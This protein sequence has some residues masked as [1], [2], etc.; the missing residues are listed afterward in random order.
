MSVQLENSSMVI[1][2]VHP[3]S[4]CEGQQAC[5]IHALTSHHMRSWRQIFREDNGLM[6]RICEHGIGHPDPD[7]MHYWRNRGE[8]YMGIHGCDGCCRLPTR[9][10]EV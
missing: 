6:E 4:A 5:A 7:G 3:E 9:L 1:G 10:M 2:G 8:T